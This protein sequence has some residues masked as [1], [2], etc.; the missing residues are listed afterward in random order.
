MDTEALGGDS[1]ASEG[2]ISGLLTRAPSTHTQPPPTP[3]VSVHAV[4]VGH[5]TS[6]TQG[7]GELLPQL[8]QKSA[9]VCQ[10]NAIF[11]CAKH[12]HIF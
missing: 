8:L 5:R 1:P 3:V 9:A 4:N 7:H 12:G 2:L 10:V 11:L 6:S